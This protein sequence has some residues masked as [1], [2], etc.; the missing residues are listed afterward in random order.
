MFKKLTAL[1]L[2]LTA[3]AFA[4]VEF[5]RS[6]DLTRVNASGSPAAGDEPIHLLAKLLAATSGTASGTTNAGTPQ[7]IASGDAEPTFTAEAETISALSATPATALT[8]LTITI[9]TGDPVAL[10][11][12]TGWQWDSSSAAIT[13]AE[14]IEIEVTAGTAIFA[15]RLP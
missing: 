11:A 12:G 14:T 4:A 9:G 8:I 15:T 2:A 6:P 7:V 5:L 1:L 3:T 13:N 10:P